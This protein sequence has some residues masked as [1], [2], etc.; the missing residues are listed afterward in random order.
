MNAGDHENRSATGEDTVLGAPLS[1]GEENEDQ[2][3]RKEMDG[4]PDIQ[5]RSY[6]M[7]PLVWH[8]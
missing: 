4:L 3:G 7:N 2:A 5:H 1:P 8:A 6:I